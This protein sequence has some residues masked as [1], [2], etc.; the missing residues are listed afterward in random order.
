MGEVNETKLNAYFRQN[1]EYREKIKMIEERGQLQEKNFEEKI[2][3]EY[4]LKV[5]D[6]ETKL[7]TMTD[8]KVKLGQENEKLVSEQKS[9]DKNFEQS[10]QTMEKRI[11]EITQENQKIKEEKVQIENDT[12]CQ[13]VQKEETNLKLKVRKF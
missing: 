7:K 4:L 5:K 9:R 13:T 11:S 10:L 12:K 1:N 2:Q 6:L 3:G 8:E